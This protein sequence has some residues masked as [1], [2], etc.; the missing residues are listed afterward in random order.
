MIAT[1]ATAT[2]AIAQL[3]LLLFAAPAV[4]PA[5]R[6]TYPK[7]PGIDALNYAFRLELTDTS[8]AIVG[9]LTMD[10]RFVATGVQAVR[11]DLAN[12]IASRGG[13]G[14]RVS[15]V[16]LNGAAVR[17]THENDALTVP[18]GS[19][20]A[21]QQRARLV[22]RYAGIPATG[23]AIG[24]NRHGDRTFFSDNWPNRARH[25]LPTIDHV[26]D[27]AT[28][29]FI[30]TAPSHYQVV[31]NGLQ[32]EV[33][34]LPGNRRRTHWRNSVPISPWLYVLG[35]AR[36]AMQT[37]D[38]FEGKPIETW[39]YP[40][41][42]DAGFGDFATPTKSVLAFYSDY[43]GPFAYERLANIQS[44]SVSGGMESASAILYHESSVTGTRSVRWRN[45]VIH[46]IAHQWFGN[47]VTEY[48][49][50]DVWLSEGFATYFTLLYIEH[51]YGREEFV[52]GLENSQRTVRSYA[53][54]HPGYT[55][56]HK[57]L[58]RMEDVTSSHT[59]QKGSW[60]LHMLRG[61]VGDE[62]FQRGIRAYYR[63]HFNAHATTADFRR[64]MEEAS[65]KEL[66]WF[67]QQWLYEGGNLK[68]AGGWTYD[69]RAKQVRITLDQVQN[70]G[71][72]FTMPL[73]VAIHA[74]GQ[75]APTMH[76]VQ[77]NAQRN[78]FTIDVPA[79]P[80]DVRLDPNLWVL[81]EATFAR[82]R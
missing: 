18:L 68:V 19:A 15:D 40:Q 81:M 31:S 79:E 72:T 65:G 63:E 27:K 33:T 8:D 32:A 74:A 70:D 23:L 30:V 6:D 62:A 3:A 60:V 71:S 58:D 1:L 11:L 55:I 44:N 52:R 46:E 82:T 41:D 21:V 76:R 57:N 56:I 35:V 12:A 7:N 64:A 42:R 9:E 54:T 49:W 48:D 34:D 45:V 67:F 29:E 2:S 20:P 50:N 61:V 36:F 28:S 38:T 43:V 53:A 17:F 22:V 26:Y 77:I 5:P 75:A 16:T 47:A 39:V 4:S 14:M 66:G 73:D 59:Y 25:W 80:T 78:V 24:P 10:L 37:V 51:A 69:A 13:K